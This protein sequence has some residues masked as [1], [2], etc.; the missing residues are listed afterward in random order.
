MIVQ[1]RVSSTAKQNKPKPIYNKV[2]FSPTVLRVDLS[3]SV[4]QVP[5]PSSPGSSS[6]A[7]LLRCSVAPLARDF[8]KVKEWRRDGQRVANWRHSE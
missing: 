8:A 2:F 6:S 7:V 4:A 3:L 1:H 5:S